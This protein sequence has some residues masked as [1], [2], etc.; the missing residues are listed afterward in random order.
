MA[1]AQKKPHSMVD[2]HPLLHSEALL[3]IASTNSEDISL[4]L[5]TKLVAFNLLTHLLVIE[6]TEAILIFKFNG[7]L[8]SCL[9]VRDVELHRWPL[10]F[11]KNVQIQV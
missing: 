11:I 4:P 8:L 10:V 2:K 6:M 7:L 9:W 1:L 5:I 3:I